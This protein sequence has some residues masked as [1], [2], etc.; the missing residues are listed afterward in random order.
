MLDFLLNLDKY[1]TGW[2]HDMGGWFY[3]VIFLVIFAETGL[4]IVP[5]RGI[6]VS[7]N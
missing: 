2:S 7:M 5:E 1:L 4:V 3:L 6:S